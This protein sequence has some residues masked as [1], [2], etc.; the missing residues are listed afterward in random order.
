[1]LAA[2]DL[3]ELAESYRSEVSKGLPA[4][5]ARMPKGQQV[6]HAAGN[7]Y[8][9][10][11]LRASLHG[12]AAGKVGGKARQM[13]MGMGSTASGQA[14]QGL[15]AQ[16]EMSRRAAINSGD[17]RSITPADDRLRRAAKRRSEM[18][19]GRVSPRAFNQTRS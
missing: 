13:S 15:T 5:L 3:V 2:M 16:R 7:G 17:R 8:V 12:G 6:G 18:S 4:A 11:K 14:K 10:A 1:M 9:G 19:G